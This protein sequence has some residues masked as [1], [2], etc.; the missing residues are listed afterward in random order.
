M[1]MGFDLLGRG[2]LAAFFFDGVVFDDAFLATAFSA[3]AFF[4]TA[5]L[6]AVAFFA[7]AFFFAATFF[8][9]TGFLLAMSFFL[10]VDFFVLE[11]FLRAGFFRAMRKVYQISA[12]FRGFQLTFLCCAPS[13]D[14]AREF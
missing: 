7:T 14:L 9:A 5:G 1:G 2:A 12:V 13:V 10:A 4:F 6:R 8:F 11:A 3:A